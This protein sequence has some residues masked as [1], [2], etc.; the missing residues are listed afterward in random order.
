MLKLM[1]LPLDNPGLLLKKV[2]NRIRRNLAGAQAGLPVSR[3]SFESPTHL[4]VHA[5]TTSESGV[6][7]SYKVAFPSF[8]R[9][10]M[11]TTLALSNVTSADIKLTKNSLSITVALSENTPESAVAWAV[12]SM[13][14][15]SLRPYTAMSRDINITGAGPALM[16][17]AVGH[18]IHFKEFSGSDASEMEAS[19]AIALTDIDRAQPFFD[20]ATFNPIGVKIRETSGNPSIAEIVIEDGISVNGQRF[21]LDEFLVEKLHTFT[22]ARLR[23]AA[24]SL[25]NSSLVAAVAA[26]GIVLTTDRHVEGLHPELNQIITQPLPDSFETIAEQ[27]VVWMARSE[28][29]RR[30]ALTHHAA[31]WQAQD[32]WPLASILLV[33]N[34]S[35]MLEAA[36]DF[37]SKQTYPNTEILV[38]VHG[39]TEAAASKLLKTHI[40]TLGDRIQIHAFDQSSPLGEVYGQLTK[41]ARGEYLAKFDDDDIYGQHHLWDAI[42]SLRYSGAGL[43]G[44]TPA[45]TFLSGTEE[46]L[47]RPF[48]IEETYNKYIIGPTMVMSKAALLQAGGW[49]PSPWAV[50]KALIDRFLDAGLGVYRAG[51]LG[52]LYVRHNKGH[53]WVRDEAHFREQAQH[54]WTGKDV[55]RIREIVLQADSVSGR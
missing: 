18:R 4:R 47:L 26:T 3:Q 55:S 31:A 2:R 29:Q 34:R 27:Q 17:F 50:D 35:E 53:T 6:K 5:F 19:Q 21:A 14:Q 51:Q 49:R 40:K 25:A 42:I 38:G 32:E 45:I 10:Q 23:V 36:V 43:F 52:W 8:L 1:S 7:F 44:R 37:A 22:G 30:L 54:A 39:I 48:G 20:V 12:A 15:P 41:I 13:I 16:P 9:V 24:T 28:M 46:L 11:R 33:T